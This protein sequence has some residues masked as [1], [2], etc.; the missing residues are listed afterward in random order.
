MPAK[1]SEKA[2]P[3]TTTTTTKVEVE[4]TEEKKAADPNA[5]VEEVSQQ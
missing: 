5:M 2:A 3:A 1:P 4:K